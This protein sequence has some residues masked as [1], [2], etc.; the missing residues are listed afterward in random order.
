[1]SVPVISAA[2]LATLQ[3]H[4]LIVFED[5]VIYK[6]GAPIDVQTT[7]R[8]EQC[9]AGPIP[10]DLLA[11]WQL[12]LGGRL[13]YELEAPM[14]GIERALS[15]TQL[16]APDDA[17]YR[18]LFGWIEHE[19]ELVLEVEEETAEDAGETAEEKFSED[20]KLSVLPFGGFEYL[21]RMYVVV[22][23]GPEYGHALC[24]KQGLPPAWVGRLHEDTVVTIAPS[25]RALFRQL[26]LEESPEAPRDDDDYRHGD[27]VWNAIQNFEDAAPE[28]APLAAKLRALVKSAVLDWRTPY[29]RGNLAHAPQMAALAMRHA[30]KTDDVAMLNN[31]VKQKLDINAAIAGGL[32]SIEVALRHGCQAVSE[33]LLTMNVDVSRAIQMAGGRVSRDICASLLQRGAI[34]DARAAIDAATNGNGETAMLIA[35]ALKV[36][37]AKAWSRLKPDSMERARNEEAVVKRIKQGDYF[38]DRTPEQHLEASQRLMQFANAVSAI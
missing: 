15:F 27:E 20:V 24:W 3:R 35:V 32:S 33:V 28:H 18:D 37:D 34:P 12:A 25:V 13:D 10:E 6:A 38:S 16:F 26:H 36:A 23:P 7:K 11:L 14:V 22:Q 19:Q 8:I 29:E 21:E 30:V 2:E 5:R 9:L 4:A 31:L 1:M 17:G